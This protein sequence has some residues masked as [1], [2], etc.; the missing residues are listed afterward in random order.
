MECSLSELDVACVSVVDVVDVT[1]AVVV[2][3]VDDDGA[4][5]SAGRFVEQLMGSESWCVLCPND[6][7]FSDAENEVEAQVEEGEAAAL[8]QL[9]ALPSTPPS[10]AAGPPFFCCCCCCCSPSAAASVAS[11]ST[12]W[13]ST[14]GDR[15]IFI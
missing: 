7:F 4:D 1:A 5:S 12:T 14:N 13:Q 2:V 9:A 11:T 6:A 10:A 3:N 8:Q 15:L